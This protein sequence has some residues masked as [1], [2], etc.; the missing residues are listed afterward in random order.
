MQ[1]QTW[2][3]LGSTMEAQEHRKS[4]D[5]SIQDTPL[6]LALFCRTQ[7]SFFL[8]QDKI[9]KDSHC[10]SFDTKSIALQK[11]ARCLFV[12]ILISEGL[13][14]IS[15]YMVIDVSHFGQSDLIY[16]MYKKSYDGS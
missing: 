4:D 9:G 10:L 16:S 3:D 2:A 1:M 12:E 8:T 15:L 5:T 13:N 14:I 6:W 7:M 11:K